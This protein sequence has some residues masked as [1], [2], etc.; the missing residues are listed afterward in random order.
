MT[1]S[2]SQAAQEW[3]T[4]LMNE[5]FPV[6]HDDF[7]KKHQPY[8]TALEALRL[9][10]LLEDIPADA[11]VDIRRVGTGWAVIR[12]NGNLEL[13]PMVYGETMGEALDKLTNQGEKK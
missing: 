1:K 7:L 3:L 4:D 8:Q 13:L 9:H 10:A 2:R 12:R 5:L 11:H 6:C